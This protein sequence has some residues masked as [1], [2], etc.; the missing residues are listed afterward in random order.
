MK[1]L[2]VDNEALALDRL[3]RMLLSLGYT[4]ITRANTIEEALDLAQKKVFDLVFLDINMPQINGIE[5]GYEFRYRYKECAIIY[6]ADLSEVV[7]RSDKGFS[8]YAQKIS[9]LETLLTPYQLARI[10]RSYLINLN[11]IKEIQT[12]E[13]SKLRFYFHSIGEFV[14]Y[15]KDGAKFFRQRFSLGL[16]EKK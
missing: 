5:L 7:L 8:Y 9:D 3:E 13:Q 1:I 12:I 6:Q 11:K 15:S 4:K 16:G 10:Y 14:D 2:I